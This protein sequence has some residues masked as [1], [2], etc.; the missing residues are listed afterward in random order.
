[1]AARSAPKRKAFFI[2]EQSL[3]RAKKVLGVGR[4]AARRHGATIVTVNRSDFEPLV[5]S[6]PSATETPSIT[7]SELNAES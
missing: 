2:D 6:Q 7:P 4:D 5:S 1:M 3:R